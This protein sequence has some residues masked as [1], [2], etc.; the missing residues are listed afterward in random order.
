MLG[1]IFIAASVVVATYLV[2]FSAGKRQERE[3]L[4]LAALRA[5]Q[6]AKVVTDGQAKVLREEA[7]AEEKRQAALAREKTDAASQSSSPSVALNDGPD[8]YPGD[9]IRKRDSV[10]P[11]SSSGSAVQNVYIHHGGVLGVRQTSN[12]APASP[13]P[14]QP[15]PQ[16]R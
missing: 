14:A 3:D 8:A 4:N 15:M 11:R 2:G 12:E 7:K 13:V 9:T 16:S 10:R 5:A 6:V 1:R